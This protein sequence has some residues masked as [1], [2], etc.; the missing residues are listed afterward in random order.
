ML[1]LFVSSSRH[2]AGIAYLFVNDQISGWLCSYRVIQP[3]RALLP[4]PWGCHHWLSHSRR[5][6]CQAQQMKLTDW[7]QEPLWFISRFEDIWRCIL[8]IS[9]VGFS[10]AEG[11]VLYP[12]DHDTLS[13][14]CRL[15]YKAK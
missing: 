1:V 14:F 9:S 15:D 4:F 12:A 7:Y 5:Q 3:Y 6:L 11:S 10:V 2:E 13:P 8:P